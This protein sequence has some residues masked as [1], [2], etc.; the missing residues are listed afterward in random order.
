MTETLQ[1]GALG[2][3]AIVLGAI[4]LWLRDYL[5]NRDAREDQTNTYLQRLIDE[6][7]TDRKS[8]EDVLRKLI[9][10][11]IRAKIQLTE[12][13]EIMVENQEA[14]TEGLATEKEQNAERHQALMRYLTSVL[15]RSGG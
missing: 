1:Y 10:E 4:G 3:L 5:K 8:R 7:R 14:I 15:A 11:D 13:L 2:L 6:D 12:T 9:A